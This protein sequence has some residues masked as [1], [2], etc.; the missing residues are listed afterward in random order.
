MKEF[1]V[2][3]HLAWQIAAGEAGAAKHQYIEKEHMLIGI[4]SLE[5]IV[6]LDAE[7]KLPQQTRQALQAESDDVENV[8]H[9]FELDSTQLRRQ[10]REKLGRGDYE[11]TEKIIH[12]SEACKKFFSRADKLATSGEDISCLHLLAAILGEPGDVIEGILDE[13]NAKPEDLRQ[14]ALGYAAKK[15]ELHQEPVEVRQE[16]PKKKPQSG[17]HYL[18]TYGRDLT[19]EAQ[20]GKLGPFIGRRQELL[21]VIQT[22]ARKTKN[23]PVLV[24]EAGVG[25]TA[26]VE[27]L[28][29][30]VAQGKDPYVLAG[31]R[32]V[33]LNIGGLVG[34]SK[35]RGEFEQRL[36]SIIEEARN[37][38]EVIVFIDEIHNVVGAGRAEGSMDAANLL[39]PA[40]SRGD[41]RCIGATTIAEYRRYI[42]SDSALERRFEKII[43]NEPSPDEALEILRGVRP[44]LEEHHGVH[45]TDRA[46]EASV[47]LSIRLDG[48]HQLPDKA[49]DLVDKAG[50]RTRIPA[51]SMRLDMKKDEAPLEKKA[52]GIG[53]R[54]EVTEITIAQV[55]SDKIGVPLEVITGHLEGMAR[56]RLLELEPFLKKQLVGQDEALERVCQRLLMAH[57]GLARRR[58][59]LAVFLFLG[60]TGVG[61]T[62][63]ARLLAE[64]LFGSK[65]DMIRLDMSEYMEEHS[66]AKLIGSPPGYVGYEQEGQLTGKMRT[67]PYSV[68]LLDEIEKAHPR[69]SDLFL[70]V[71]DDG[72][73]TD[74]KGRTIDAK[75][76]IFIM[77][78]N[79]R[80]DD[81]DE[82]PPIYDRGQKA[83]GIREK[84]RQVMRPEFL[85]R[86]DEIIIFNTL[87]MDDVKKI[88]KPILAEVCENLKKQHNVT[89]EVREE[90]EECLARA[91]YSP[92]Y[93]ARELR[94]TVERL[95]QIPLSRLILSGALKKHGYWQITCSDEKVSI[96]PLDEETPREPHDTELLGEEDQK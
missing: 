94:R 10:V 52:G 20:E 1:S 84:L 72:R 24:G 49:I 88:L 29:M 3:L 65:S 96:I 87:S 23:N 27:A 64:F 66:V 93:G 47:D 92:H 71:F 81:I 45:I 95:V 53:N 41:L 86:I 91:G 13:A 12:R 28:A 43:V 34:G 80:T 50:A 38:P 32:I 18:D 61:K 58:G 67:N 14:R 83:E 44:K 60:P 55:L 11:H 40:L 63:L 76:A 16:E 78:S 2:S 36:T 90:A 25:K 62:E 30:R 59:P 48:D 22:L 82:T 73:L 68:V 79:I 33:E 77:T 57:A 54:A 85:N 9:G 56:S 26:I 8:L 75:N 19:R 39:K 7:A 74:S 17:T 6:M 42:E 4:C 46:L 69:V 51:L 15:Q 21:Q 89:L 70:Q 31:K 37:N 35:Y 5:K